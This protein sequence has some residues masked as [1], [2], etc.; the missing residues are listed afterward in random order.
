MKLIVA[1]SRGF[2]DEFYDQ[3]A[4]KITESW[5]G[6]TEIVSGGAR[7]ADSL[8]ELY[9]KER[10]LKLTVF[11]ADWQLHGKGAGYIRN[12]RMA[13]YADACFVMWDGESRGSKHMITLA[14][15]AGIPVLVW[16]PNETKDD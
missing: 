6:V 15:K 14:E 10:K 16:R 7:G 13:D 5:S 8:G 2:T 12:Q 9:A 11:P 4:R 3:L 1:G